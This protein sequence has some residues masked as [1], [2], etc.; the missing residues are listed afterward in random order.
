LINQSIKYSPIN[1]WLLM[2]IWPCPWKI[3]G[4]PFH[5]KEICI[6]GLITQISLILSFPHNSNGWIDRQKDSAPWHYTDPEHYYYTRRTCLFLIRIIPFLNQI[7]QQSLGVPRQNLSLVRHKHSGLGS[8]KT[9]WMCTLYSNWNSCFK[10]M[11]EGQTNGQ[12]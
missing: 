12:T 6:P 8:Y 10:V 11:H 7:I 1:P 3:I 4:I 2:K 9:F 5:H